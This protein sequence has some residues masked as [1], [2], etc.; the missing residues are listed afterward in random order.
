MNMEILVSNLSIEYNIETNLFNIKNVL[1][2]EIS[3]G[4]IPNRVVHSTCWPCG[5]VYSYEL[6]HK[7]EQYY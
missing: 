6:T 3:Q 7:G 5:C 1:C 4:L 2:L